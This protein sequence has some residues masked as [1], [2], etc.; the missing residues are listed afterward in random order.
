MSSISG[1]L[2]EDEVTMIH[3]W[4]EGLHV[5]FLGDL[6]H[7]L[8]EDELAPLCGAEIVLAAAAANRRSAWPIWRFWSMPSARAL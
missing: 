5:A 7:P 2:P 8:A 4:A 3:F 6:G 1:C